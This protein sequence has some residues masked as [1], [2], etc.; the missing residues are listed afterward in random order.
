[1]NF[2]QKNSFTIVTYMAYDI[3][4]LYAIYYIKLKTHVEVG[5]DNMVGK[6]YISK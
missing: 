6:Y 3:Y 5:L 4:I 2:L 1:M